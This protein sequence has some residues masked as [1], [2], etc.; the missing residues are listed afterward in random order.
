[1]SVKVAINGVGRI[2]RSFLR[3]AWSREELE[4]EAVN[5]LGDIH[6]IA[7]LLKHDSVYGPAPF[8]VEVSE[9][10]TALLIDGRE[11]RFFSEQ[12]PAS[13]PWG[14]LEIGVVVESTGVFRQY[15][16]AQLHRDA[17]AQK[18][19][20][21]AP[22][23]SEPADDTQGTVL[24]GLN[25]DQLASCVISSNGSCTTNAGAPVVQILQEALGIEKAML[26]TIHSYT[27]SQQLVDGPSKDFRRGRAAAEN[28][29]PTST[30]A[31]EATTKVVPEL[32]GKFD[33]VA[34]RVPTPAGS[35]ADITFLAGRDTSV[36]EVNDI[37]RRAA[38]EPRWH[39]VLAVTEEPLVSTD[40]VGRPYGAIVDLEMTRVVAGNLVKVMSWY[41][42]EAGY[43]HTLAEHVIATGKHID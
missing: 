10:E 12:D 24:M 21:S 11:V 30:G 27:S 18:V 15:D 7:Y 8:S 23:K 1:M 19:V 29:V 20:I 22:A 13:L 16:Q 26:N 33:G 40:I 9:D 6:N 38:E 35:L 37:L 5:D 32:S 14:E 39:K 4:I 41:D 25:E 2:G 31:A 17:G 3:T 28:M 34:M 36:D 43:T 42:N